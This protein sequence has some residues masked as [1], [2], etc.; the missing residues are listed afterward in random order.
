MT[1]T[2]VE[3]GT[4]ASLP[5]APS[6]KEELEA[7]G[8][9]GAKFFPDEQVESYS[10]DDNDRL[11]VTLKKPYE[12]AVGDGTKVVLAQQVAADIVDGGLENVSGVTA[13]KKVPFTQVKANI[14]S[15]KIQ[16]RSLIVTTDNALKRTLELDATRLLA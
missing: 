13:F 3:Q 12:I 9:P 14:L 10:I 8:V 4:S 6:L 5:K 7:L 11:K 16:G 15:L 1:S 2:H